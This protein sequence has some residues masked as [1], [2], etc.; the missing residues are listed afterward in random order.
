MYRKGQ[1]TT[2]QCVVGVQMK[3]ETFLLNEIQN[4]V[5]NAQEKGNPFSY[6]WS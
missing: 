6:S 1:A 5:V 2:E 4:Y 3:C